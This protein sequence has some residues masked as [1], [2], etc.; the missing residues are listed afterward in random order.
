[1]SSSTRPSRLG[2]EVGVGAH[3]A[4]DVLPG[5]GDVG[6]VAVRPAELLADAVLPLDAA[7]ARRASASMPSRSGLTACPDVDE[8]VADDQHVLA[9][10]ALATAAAIRLSL[11]PATRW[12]TSTPTRRSGPGPEVAQVLGEVVDA[13]RGTPRRRPRCAGRRPRPSRRARRRAGPRRRSGWP[14][15]PGPWRRAR[16]PTR[17]PYASAWPR[18]PARAGGTRITGTPSSRKPGPSGKVRRL[19]RRSSSVTVP[20]SR[21]TA[22]ISPHQSVVTSSTTRPMSAEIST[23]RPRRG[24]RQSVFRTSEP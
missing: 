8:R 19:P 11:E 12:S 21:S 13:A 9:D 14:G 20:R 15:R 23:A 24:A 2:L 4:E 6:L 7:R 5:P 17:T 1:M 3:P 16:R 22:T 18:A 10:R